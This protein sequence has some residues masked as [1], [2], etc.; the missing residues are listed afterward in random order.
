MP[1]IDTAPQHL[2]QHI[3]YGLTLLPLGHFAIA[4]RRICWKRYMK[5]R[6]INNYY[7]W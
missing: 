6:Q 4:K 1:L 2:T 5:L 7:S 3:R